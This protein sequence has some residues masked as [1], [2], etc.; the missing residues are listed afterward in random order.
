MINLRISQFS[1]VGNLLYRSIFLSSLSY[2]KHLSCSV[3]ALGKIK[4][5]YHNVSSIMLLFKGQ[6]IDEG[7]YPVFSVTKALLL[8]H[9]PATI[10]ATAS[11]E[12]IYEPVTWE[13]QDII[14]E[15]CDQ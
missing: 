7:K 8:N 15:S 1:N 6:C 12:Y 10:F 3:Q 5:V 4:A 2:V 9:H 14:C 11:R 13:Q